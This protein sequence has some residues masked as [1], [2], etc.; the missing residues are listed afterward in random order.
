[1][2]P[3]SP[4]QSFQYLLTFFLENNRTAKC[5]RA[6]RHKLFKNLIAHCVRIVAEASHFDGFRGRTFN[7]CHEIATAPPCCEEVHCPIEA[8]PPS[9]TDVINLI[10]PSLS[11]VIMVLETL[12]SRS[13]KET[14]LDGAGLTE[15]YVMG[16]TL[17]RWATPRANPPKLQT[18]LLLEATRRVIIEK[19]H[20]YLAPPDNLLTHPLRLRN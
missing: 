13:M 10:Y 17:L 7:V 4:S 19:V 15:V 3:V 14:G 11:A 18:L 8:K 9:K 12:T 20:G 5:D 1:M 16:K 2:S 6:I